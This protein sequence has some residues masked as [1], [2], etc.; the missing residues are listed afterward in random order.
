MK[1][2]TAR[3]EIA[4]ALNFQKYPVIPIDLA[5]TDEYGVIG[6]KVRVD[7]G[8][9]YTIRATV[10]AYSDE[11]KLVVVSKNVCVANKITYTDIMEDVEYANVPIIKADQEIVVV[12][13]NSKRKEIYAIDII[14]TGSRID[15]HCLE[16]IKLEEYK[17]FD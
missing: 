1:K 14:K 4:K 12:M 2:L 6:T 15:R 9:D 8:G 5:Q 10:R 17:V 13:Y 7:F 3:T 16:P 11:K